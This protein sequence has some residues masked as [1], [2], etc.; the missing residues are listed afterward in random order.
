MSVYY[1]L[2]VKIGYNERFTAQVIIQHHKVVQ[3]SL[4]W[5]NLHNILTSFVTTQTIPEM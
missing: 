5:P 1:L 3:P 4:G 2:R